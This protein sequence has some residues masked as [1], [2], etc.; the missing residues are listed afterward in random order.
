M[1]RPSFARPRESRIPLEWFFDKIRAARSV[2]VRR[3][4]DHRSL[5]GI[6]QRVFLTGCASRDFYLYL[7]LSP[8]DDLLI[9]PIAVSTSAACSSK[10]C[11]SADFNAGDHFYA[12]PGVQS[13]RLNLCV[14][15]FQR[16]GAQKWGAELRARARALR[17][18]LIDGAAATAHDITDNPISG[19]FYSAIRDSV[20]G[21]RQGRA[22]KVR[23]HGSATLRRITTGNKVRK[24]EDFQGDYGCNARH[25]GRFRR[26]S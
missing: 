2:F 22:H 11:F 20:V 16:R 7:A 15:L 10:H 21:E 26:F 14:S 4:R 23:T 5:R 18:L 3:V 1:R 8:H 9:E 24:K 17:L 13:L 19:A 6:D 25:A 12:N